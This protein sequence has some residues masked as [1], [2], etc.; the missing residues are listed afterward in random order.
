[1]LDMPRSRQLDNILE[2]PYLGLLPPSSPPPQMSSSPGCTSQIQNNQYRV[3]TPSHISYWAFTI[4]P[5]YTWSNHCR[6]WY[7]RTRAIPVLH[8]QLT[9]F[10][11]ASANPANPIPVIL[12]HKNH[13]KGSWPQFLPLLCL[14]TNPGTSLCDPPCGMACPFL[15]GTVRNKLSFQWQLSPDLL[16]LLYLK[17]PI[18][19]LYLNH[20]VVFIPRCG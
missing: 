12:S 2:S 18:N 20:W 11:L 4:G 15:L 16:A 1:M 13:N 7:L 6:A 3:H 9:L 10:I 14:V 8:G 5:L 17:F 19:I